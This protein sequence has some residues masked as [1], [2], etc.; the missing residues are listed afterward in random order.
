MCRVMPFWARA[1][2]KKHFLWRWYCG[3]KQIEIWFMVDGG[4][5]SYRQ[6][7]RLITFFPNIF[8]YCFCMLSGEIAKAF[9]RKVWR[10]QVAHLHNAARALSSPSRCFQLSTN[11]D[12]DF[13]CYLWCRG[14]KKP[15]RMSFSVSLVKFYWFGINWNVFMQ[16]LS[17]VY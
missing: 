6:Q 17:Y 13:C 7:V 11:L 4:L 5:Y 16:K 2:N 10:V 12:N 8:S 15:N 9:E 3:R 1:L 14:K